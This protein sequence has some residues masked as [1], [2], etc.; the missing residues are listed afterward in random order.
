MEYLELK[1]REGANYT[2][3]GT[4][5][6]GENKV[7]GMELGITGMLT[8][9]LT[10][11]GGVTMMN[12]EVTKSATP[13][14][15]GK[16][17]GNFAKTAANLMA[18]YRITEDLQVGGAYK[19]ESRRFGGQPDTAAPFNAATGIYNQPVPGYSVVD[20]FANYRVNDNLSARLNV[21]NVG[22]KDYYLAAY[23][24]GFFLYKGDSRSVKV[25]LDYA[26]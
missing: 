8:D 5:N 23:R 9:D 26:L 11:S 13:A 14:N 25:T 19:Y 1:I 18:K 17:L 24:G 15:V 4:F 16:I 21:N 3:F 2:A 10:V 22:D 6:T 7:E 20:L 12:S